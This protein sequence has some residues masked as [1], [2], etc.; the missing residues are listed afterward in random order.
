MK[1]LSEM[2]DRSILMLKKGL[3]AL[4]SNQGMY[5][6]TAFVFSTILN[7]SLFMWYTERVSAM[8]RYVVVTWGVVVCVL[9][10][11]RAEVRDL[12]K[13]D[14]GILTLLF[15]WVVVP[16]G[17]R[18]GLTH[19][20]VSYWYAHLVTFFAIYAINREDT[21]ERRGAILDQVCAGF[22]VF[23]F[24]LG[25]V[26]LYTAVT[27][28]TFGD[29]TGLDTFGVYN[30]ILAPGYDRNAFGMYAQCC[31]I[32]C[33]V[34]MNRRK[35]I[36]GKAAHLIPGAM[37][38][39]AI[40][41]CQ[42]RTSRLGVMAGI[43]VGVYGFLMY[44][45]RVSRAI[46]RHA[47]AAI[48]ALVVFVAGYSATDWLIEKAV[49][50]Y[51]SE[52][53][54]SVVVAV[55]EEGEAQSAKTAP[56]AKV[57]KGTASVDDRMV[58]WTNLIN[59]WRENPK[60]LL[61]GHGVGHIGSKLLPGTV[62]EAMRFGSVAVHNGILQI[63]ADIGIIGTVLMLA[64][65]AMALWPALR[66]FF[67]PN[68]VVYPGARMLCGLVVATFVTSLMESQ[69]LYVNTPMNMMFFYALAILCAEGKALKK[70]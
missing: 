1:K 46:V 55:T 38:F 3:L 16:F 28:K 21:P 66:L 62:A 6:L 37:M 5:L 10:L 27:G 29:G 14:T 52:K 34:G 11:E 70:A 9:R 57:V 54:A 51:N 45:I 33:F 26:L 22:A 60:Y 23:S 68:N 15:L 41:L 39:T 13:A 19:L 35:S 56:A 12:R 58:I 25:G 48:C 42:S 59:Q 40:A 44:R 61:I 30:G 65:Y 32:M 53:M 4:A 2:V 24:I 36:L 43:A 67:A 17:L 7:S 50:Y 49:N 64:F 69:P 20:N 63:M 31:V 18:F 47:A 8:Y